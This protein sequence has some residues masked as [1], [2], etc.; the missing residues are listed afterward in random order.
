M[1]PNGKLIIEIP[2]GHPKEET[3]PEI[4]TKPTET[5]GEKKEE[6]SQPTEQQQP[7]QQ[8][9]KQNEEPAGQLS[10]E[11]ELQEREQQPPQQQEKQSSEQKEEEAKKEE[12]K[13]V[14]KRETKEK[15][16]EPSQEVR[17]LM[18]SGE[19]I[20]PR[21]IDGK[22]V[23]MRIQLPDPIDASKL[24]VSVKDQDVIVMVR[25]E[26]DKYDSLSESFYY[27]RTTLPERTDFKAL[28]C[29]L[30]GNHLTIRAP[31]KDTSSGQQQQIER[32]GGEQT[33]SASIEQEESR[34]KKTV[35]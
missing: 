19:D 9:E 7:Q 22:Q 1:A 21:V 12:A 15:S 11:K 17:V 32:K 6:T 14:K 4:Q 33:T 20:L 28:K 27:R 25:D 16:K 3:K 2:I 24:K 10:E 26:Q 30:E 13:E 5:S 35:A 29:T 34:E 31:I 8:E 18:G 23:E